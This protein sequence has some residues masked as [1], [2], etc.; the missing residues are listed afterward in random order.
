MAFGGRGAFVRDLSRLP[1]RDGDEARREAREWVDGFDDF[2]SFAVLAI[3]HTGCTL[4][5]VGL[6][7]EK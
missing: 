4:S 6:F 2:L 5:G 7:L 1:F 3:V